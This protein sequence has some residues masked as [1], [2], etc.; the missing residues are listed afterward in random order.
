MT[1]RNFHQVRR[2]IRLMAAI[3]WGG[4]VKLRGTFED[5]TAIYLVQ[6]ACAKGDLFKKLIRAGGALE[7]GYV[8]REVVLPLLATLEHLHARRIFHRDIKPENIF[9]TK[10]GRAKLGDFGLAIDATTERPKSR[11]GTVR[12][13]R[14]A[15]RGGGGFHQLHLLFW[16]AGCLRRVCGTS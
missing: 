16:C 1:E 10:E 12:D 5:A 15:C 9:F 7:E 14:G 4:A 11:V 3:D 2:E 6:E 13:R 8:A